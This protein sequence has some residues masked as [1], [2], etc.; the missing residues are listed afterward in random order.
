MAEN[1]AEILVGTGVLALA[2]GF[3][4]YLVQATGGGAVAGEG[5]ATY[6]ASFRAVDGIAV[7]TEVRMAGVK[8]G[9]VTDIVLNRETFRA[10]TTVA[11]PA[12]IA[13]PDDTAMVISSEG[14]LGGNYVELVPGGSPFNLD[15]GDEILE[16]QGS[17]SLIA[18]LSRFVSGGNE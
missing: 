7:G 4:V 2:L 15:P 12:D 14:L 17:V 8:L 11:I 10:D 18:L 13:L 3:F 9:T 1:R 5:T 6:S 16:T